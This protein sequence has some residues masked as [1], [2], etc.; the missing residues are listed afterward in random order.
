MPVPSIQIPNV[1]LTAPKTLLPQNNVNNN[2]LQSTDNG[3]TPQVKPALNATFPS[4]P[5]GTTKPSAVI[6]SKPAIDN[7]AKIGSQIQQATTDLSNHLASKTLPPTNPTSDTQTNDT[8]TKTSETTPPTIE[9]QISDLMKNLGY[10]ENETATMSDADK[11][12]IVED[13]QAQGLDNSQ[14][15][16]NNPDSVA[17]HIDAMNN[18]SY[19]LST[20]EQAS[21]LSLNLQMH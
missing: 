17:S 2:A 18:G 15:D 21:V 1:G 3:Q 10:T 8:T 11:Q 6:T 5:I 14:L 12:T 20:T 13:T 9:S 16:P 19:P 7:N 4:T